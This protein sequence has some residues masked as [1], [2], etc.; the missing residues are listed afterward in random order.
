MAHA[1]QRISMTTVRLS[2]DVL[3]ATVFGDLDLTTAP[4]FRRQL[5]DVLNNHHGIGKIP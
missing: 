4:G 1:E 2:S 5:H 3:M